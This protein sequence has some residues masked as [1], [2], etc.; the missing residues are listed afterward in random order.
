[1][2]PKNKLSEI[3]N[4]WKKLSL[5]VDLINYNIIIEP[6]FVC[7]IWCFHKVVTISSLWY[8]GVNDSI[9]INDFKYT[10]IKEFVSLS[11]TE[12]FRRTCGLLRVINRDPCKGDF[13]IFKLWD[14]HRRTKLEWERET[15]SQLQ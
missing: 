6:T 3:I 15:S 9:I 8:K 10:L 1:M 14:E 13:K 11:C 12:E 5:F 4:K 2:I 7:P